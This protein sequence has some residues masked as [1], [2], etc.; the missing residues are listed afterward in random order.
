[1]ALP[2]HPAVASQV[3][4][5]TGAA[6]PAAAVGGAAT[7]RRFATAAGISLAVAPLMAAPWLRQDLVWCGWLAMAA[8]LLLVPHLRGWWGETWSL[9]AATLAIAIAFHWSP[10]VLAYAMNTNFEIGLLIAAPIM[11]WDAARLVV[12]LWFAARVQPDPLRAW[13]P[14]GLFAAGL[15]ALLPAVFPWKFGY[16]QA[17]WTPLVQS[18]DLFGPEFATLVFYAH[19][20]AIVWLVQAARRTAAGLP[21]LAGRTGLAAVAL[22]LANL[23][24]GLGAMAYW[25]AR[26]AA[27]PTVGVALVQ[28]NPEDADGVDSLRSLTEAR[29][30]GSD[31][32]PD[33]VCWPECSGGSY[34]S[35]LESLADADEVLS[36][37]RPPNAGMRPL[38]APA[39][40]LLFG[41]KIFSGHPERPRELY[42]SAILIDPAHTILGCYH[43]RHLMPFGEYVPGEDWFPDVKRYFPMQDDLTEGRD[44]VVLGCGPGVRLGV[45]LCYEDMIPR[46]A[47]TLVAAGAN[48][49][50]SL[51]NGA[52]FT[53]PLTLAQHRLLA[54]LRSVETRRCLLRCAATGQT[55]S[56]SPLG[57]VTESL[58][59]Q[60]RG[61]LEARVP[62]LEARTLASRIGPA[63]PAVAWLCVGLL[64]YRS[65]RAD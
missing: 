38:D 64:V 33:L 46:A 45:M 58:P 40:P 26:V 3:E 25:Q 54:Q 51:I 60:G 7:L 34:E 36:K 47:R 10:K 1:M 29:C 13:L 63:F 14:A 61:I 55:C 12:P 17:A 59:L 9:A 27:A 42:Q 44:P 65:R 8:A 21:P 20:G 57:V 22:V 52:A 53:E 28:S 37:S 19:A 35:S 2:A 15:E 18:V 41:G 48:V 24:Y 31:S 16:S 62:L 50:V 32:L 56:I 43:K 23:A 49:L 4:S 30:S 6:V 11:L 39:C 5:T